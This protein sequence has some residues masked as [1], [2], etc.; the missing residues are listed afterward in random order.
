[1]RG[2]D[3]FRKNPNLLARYIRE[4]VPWLEDQDSSPLGEEVKVFYTTLW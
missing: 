1:M 2:L 3:L 4:G